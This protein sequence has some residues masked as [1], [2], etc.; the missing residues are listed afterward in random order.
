MNREKRKRQQRKEEEKKKYKTRHIDIHCLDGKEMFKSICMFRLE[1]RLVFVLFFAFSLRNLATY[2]YTYIFI[3]ICKRN[4]HTKLLYY[5]IGASIARSSCCAVASIEQ[6][7]KKS[8]FYCYGINF[9]ILIYDCYRC[10][11]KAF[12]FRS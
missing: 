10:T 3:F 9:G 8:A 2:T 7:Q 11:A 6:Q 1:N 12:G 5:N 4:A